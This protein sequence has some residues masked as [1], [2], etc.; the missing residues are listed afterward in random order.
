M[1]KVGEDT[2]GED[3][4]REEAESHPRNST[5]VDGPVGETLQ[6]MAVGRFAQAGAESAEGRIGR[7]RVNDISVQEN[8]V[9]KANRKF[10]PFEVEHAFLEL[11]KGGNP[12]TDGIVISEDNDEMAM[13]MGF[14][15]FGQETAGGEDGAAENAVPRPLKV[16]DISIENKHFHL[17]GGPMNLPQVVIVA[18]VMAEEMKVGNRGPDWHE[19]RLS[20]RFRNDNNRTT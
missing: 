13:G 19:E 18:G 17:C 3:P 4:F 9:L 10:V 11:I 6:G 7:T 1:A 2:G 12:R 16:K 20:E 15:K 8:P 5:A 14:T